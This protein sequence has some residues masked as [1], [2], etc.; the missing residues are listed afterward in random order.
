MR[1][2]LSPH[3]GGRTELPSEMMR[4]AGQTMP[5]KIEDVAK[6]ASADGVTMYAIGT[7]DENAE[8][9]SESNISVDTN[10]AS[11]RIA[12]TASALNTM[13]EIT[14]GIAITRTTNFDLAFDTISRDLDSYYSLG[15]RPPNAVSADRRKIVVTT[16]N[17]AYSV[18]TREMLVLKSA[19]DQMSDR[20][21]ANLYSDGLR[22]HPADHGEEDRR[23]GRLDVPIPIQVVMPA[24]LT[25]A[26]DGALVGGLVLF[27]VV[28]SADGRTSDVMRRPQGLKIP[29]NAE[30]AVRAKPMTYSTAIRVKGGES[31][32]SIA[33]LDQI[34]GTMGFARAKIFAR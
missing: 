2:T 27:A 8:F 17:R 15:Y 16:K 4:I 13:A 9:S 29:P 24:T 18:R 1:T 19:D 11:S 23:S 6:T 33:V 30:A 7:G 10:E 26:Q 32:L 25:L 3:L 14:G 22:G 28:G 21:V 34:S 5:A 31:T 20:V 12:N